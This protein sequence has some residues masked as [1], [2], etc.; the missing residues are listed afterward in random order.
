MKVKEFIKSMESWKKSFDDGDHDINP[1]ECEMVLDHHP[2]S[3][4]GKEHELAGILQFETLNNTFVHFKTEEYLKKEK[5]VNDN[6]EAY[7]D[8]DGNLKIRNKK[9]E[10]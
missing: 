1:Y 5:W 4:N 7:I 6:T 8:E 10:K 9:N 2:L 3:K